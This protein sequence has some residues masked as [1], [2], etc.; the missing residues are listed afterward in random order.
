MGIGLAVAWARR[1]GLLFS[2]AKFTPDVDADVSFLVFNV[3]GRT[4]YW[5]DR[6]PFVEA[7]P[8]HDTRVAFGIAAAH[9]GA[10][11]MHMST[12]AAG[13]ACVCAPGGRGIVDLV[14]AGW[15][16]WGTMRAHDVKEVPRG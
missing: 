1:R 2:G 7:E 13:L 12:R 8:L 14:P 3:H 16:K 15:P 6:G 4:H 5:W 10:A 11:W 9:A